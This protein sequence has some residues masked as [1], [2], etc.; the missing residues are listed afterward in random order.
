MAENAIVSLGDLTKPATVLIEKISSAVGG[1]FK[2][3]QM[4]RV[5]KAE[6]QAEAIRAE[7]QIQVTDLHRRAFRR[8]LEEEAKKQSNIEDITQRALPLIEADAT[9][10]SVEDDWITNFFDKCRIISD[11]N[12]QQLWSR[13]LAGEANS[14]GRFSKKTV[15]LL[16]DL[17]KTDAELFVRLCGFGWMIGGFH[18]L[19]FDP[20]GDIYARHGINFVSLA[21][22]ENL[23]LIRFGLVAS[24]SRAGLPKSVP[25]SYYGRQMNLILSKE[26][27]NV[28]DLGKV[29]LARAGQELALVCGATP[30]EGFYEFVYDRWAKQSLV[31]KQEEIEGGPEASEKPLD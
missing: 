17:G 21:H 5:A 27:D 25:V 4:V 3:F 9:P 6:A 15:N 13:I 26:T 20:H 31:P 14:P 22:L 30:V 16:G 18:P 10:E 24:F 1:V 19:V 12:M 28:L 23:G 11:A 8:F 2:P 7:A 29:L